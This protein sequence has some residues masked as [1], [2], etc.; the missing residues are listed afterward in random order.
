MVGRLFSVEL[1]YRVRDL[2]EIYGSIGSKGARVS[3]S[4]VEVDLRQLGARARVA[5]LLGVHVRLRPPQPHRHHAVRRLDAAGAAEHRHAAL[6]VRAR[7]DA[8]V[9]DKHT[10]RLSAQREC[11]AGKRSSSHA[12]RRVGCSPRGGAGAG[13]PRPS[14]SAEKH[15]LH[16]R[17]IVGTN[18]APSCQVCTN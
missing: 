6:A 13:R 17:C 15:P 7:S 14:R 10:P 11:S 18:C 3:N 12:H 2:R 1:R 9:Y 5:L 8:Y 16:T 4:P